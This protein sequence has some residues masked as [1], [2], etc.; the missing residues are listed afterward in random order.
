M[1]RRHH[2]RPNGL[3]GKQ[4]D[5]LTPYGVRESNGPVSRVSG[6]QIRLLISSVFALA[7]GAALAATVPQYR[8]ALDG[9]ADWSGRAVQA[10]EVDDQGNNSPR[11][12]D[13][14]RPARRSGPTVA[15]D[16]VRFHGQDFPPVPLPCICKA[17]A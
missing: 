12:P 6:E 16:W 14:M 7:A 4:P 5:L 10:A 11:P 1:I 9:D 3:A 2:I 17:M 15:M 8:L 13:I